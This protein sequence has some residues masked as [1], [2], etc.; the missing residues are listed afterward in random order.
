[1]DAFKSRLGTEMRRRFASTGLPTYSEEEGRSEV[2]VLFGQ[3][4][5][6]GEAP[7]HG[8]R[9]T[10][11]THRPCSD[12]GGHLTHPSVANLEKVIVERSTTE[13]Y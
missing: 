5:S 1:M 8:A 13:S 3:P 6:N 12:R 2:C 4:D 11:T 7:R 9:L 10:D